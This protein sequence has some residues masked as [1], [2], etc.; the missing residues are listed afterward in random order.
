MFDAGPYLV[1]LVPAL[2]V[3][4]ASW[5]LSRWSR[6]Q[7]Q[8]IIALENRTEK[9]IE[10]ELRLVKQEEKMHSAKNELVKVDEALSEVRDNMARRADVEKLHDLLL[11]L[12]GRARLER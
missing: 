7:D 10:L 12:L 6:N 11:Q 5:R 4:I 8:Q 2:L 9:M 3:A 1:S